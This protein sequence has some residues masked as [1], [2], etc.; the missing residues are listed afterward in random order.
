MVD[1]EQSI[2]D[3]LD[4][5]VTSEREKLAPMTQED[6]LLCSEKIDSLVNTLGKLIATPVTPQDCMTNDAIG[7]CVLARLQ[8][9]QQLTSAIDRLCVM[10]FDRVMNRTQRDEL[11][12]EE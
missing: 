9:I 7:V 3:N 12:G 10:L 5:I 6:L 11:L 2:A 4:G 1:T 8:A